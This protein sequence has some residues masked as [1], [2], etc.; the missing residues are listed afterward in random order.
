MKRILSVA[1]GLVL[2]AS[3]AQAQTITNGFTFSVASSPGNC[4]TGNHYHSNTGGEFGNPAGKA[5]VG[6]FASECVRGL[7][8]YN[9][10]GLAASPNAFVTFNVFRAGGLFA[11][12][13]DFPFNGIINVFAYQGNNAEDISDYQAASIGFIGGFSTVGL[14]VGNVI[15]LD[16]TGIFNAAIMG[17][18]SSL[19]IRLQVADG[20]NTQGGAWTFDEFR[21]TSEDLST[22]VVPEPIS[23]ALLG[24]GLAG[25]AAMRRRRR[26]VADED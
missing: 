14:A 7:S 4:A 15:S 20:T 3:V 17:S 2:T 18:L 19:G 8:E 13:N 22:N 26:K 11:G 23:M 21:L 10:G 24:T 16:I 5:E 12:T 6:E 9:L 1:V 25:V